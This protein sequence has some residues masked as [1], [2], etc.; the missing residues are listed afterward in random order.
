MW[1]YSI[2]V[3]QDGYEA[4]FS[5]VAEEQQDKINI[6]E[7]LLYLHYIGIYRVTYCRVHTSILCSLQ[8]SW[9]KHEREISFPITVLQR[10][11]LFISINNNSKYTAEINKRGRLL[12]HMGWKGSQ[13]EGCD[14]APTL[15]R[16]LP[17]SEMKPRCP[18][19]HTDTLWP[20]Y[21]GR[22]FLLLL[23]S[24]LNRRRAEFFSDGC[25]CWLYR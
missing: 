11:I 9:G 5:Y 2:W 6:S 20:I 15:K 25:I 24:W 13:F 17:P 19:I 8:L 22:V 4:C 12:H 23:N 7:R 18:N 14:N 3:F 16:K 10:I 21:T 1:T